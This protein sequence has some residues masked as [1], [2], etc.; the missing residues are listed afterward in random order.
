MT[1]YDPFEE[2]AV[3]PSD[4]SLDL[5]AKKSRSGKPKLFQCTGYGNCRMVF[6]RSEHLARHMRKHTGEKPFQCVVPGCERR[7]SRFDNMMQHTQTHYKDR[8]SPRRSKPTK[9]KKGKRPQRDFDNVADDMLPPSPPLSRR[10]SGEWRPR[11]KSQ[12]RKNYAEMEEEDDVDELSNDSDCDHPHLSH[13][14]YPHQQIMDPESYAIS[15]QRAMFAEMRRVSRDLANG[16]TSSSASQHC[17]SSP[18]APYSPADSPPTPPLL[19]SPSSILMVHPLPPLGRR[20]RSRVTPKVQF[21]PYAYQ[22]RHSDPD[23]SNKSDSHMILPRLASYLASNPDET[24]ESYLQQND[25]NLKP[26][27]RAVSWPSVP[28][29]GRILTRR[30]SIQDLTEPIDAFSPKKEPLE[31]QEDGVDLTLDEIEAIQAL[32]RFRKPTS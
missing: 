4:M 16:F 32:G 21:Q 24:P 26:P 15:E 29:A 8:A 11:R 22:N 28:V 12:Q 14:R 9:S 30:L 19:P 17:R 10:D 3:S 2:M 1:D 25:N 6:T 5:P 23:I 13:P 20:R 27:R 31:K 18:S 7:F